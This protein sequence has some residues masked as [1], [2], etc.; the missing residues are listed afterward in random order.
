MDVDKANST[1]NLEDEVWGLQ[2]A[3]SKYNEGG[4]RTNETKEKMLIWVDF[5]KPVT[6]RKVAF[7]PRQT[8]IEAA[9][10]ETPKKFK[11]Y[12]SNDTTCHLKS[13]WTKL[14]EKE[15]SDRVENFN[16]KR[17]CVVENQHRGDKYRCLAFEIDKVYKKGFASFN[18]L[19]FFGV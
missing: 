4:W 14:C 3:F 18:W 6:P 15:H 5:E 9:K 7:R 8:D 1:A 17:F 12:G 13:Q 2:R 16:E 19:R 11:F 10:I